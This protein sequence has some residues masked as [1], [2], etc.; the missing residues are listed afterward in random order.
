MCCIDQLTS[1]SLAD[2]LTDSSLMSASGGKADVRAI[3][4]IWHAHVN[5]AI[6]S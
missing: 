4:C 6:S 5:T 2:L 1:Q 3:L